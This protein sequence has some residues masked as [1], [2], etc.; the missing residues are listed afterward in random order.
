MNADNSN[1]PKLEYKTLSDLARILALFNTPQVVEM[2]VGEIAKAV[3]MSSSKISRMF[4][5]LDA[6]GLFERNPETGK[7][8]LGILFFE[9]GL[10]Y[11]GNLPFRKIIR[12]HIIQMAAEKNV[13]VSCS[14]LKNGKI[15]VVDRVQNLNFD[16]MTYR[17]GMNVPIHSTSVG[18]VLLAGL[19]A[20]EQDE[21]LKSNELVKYTN[22]TVVDPNAIRKNLEAVKKRGF[23]TD[24]GETHEDVNCVAAPIV[25]SMGQVVAALS[26]TDEESRTSSEELFQFADYLKEKA[27]FISHQLGY[28]AILF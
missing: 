8:R 26:L 9:L 24:K 16:L 14:V 5:T 21:I 19:S 2:G 4:K 13:T 17:V 6:E 3:N 20:E 27:M 7:Y 22:A 1:G 10:I 23:A 28:K 15:I 11:A 25:D 12:P 18:K